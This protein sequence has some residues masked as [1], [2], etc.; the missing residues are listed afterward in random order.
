[1]CTATLHRRSARQVV[2]TVALAVPLLTG[3]K[4]YRPVVGGP[5]P[6]TCGGEQMG[7]SEPDNPVVVA[8]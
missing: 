3:P 1:M 6:A 2:C 4:P 5:R 8:R 7:S